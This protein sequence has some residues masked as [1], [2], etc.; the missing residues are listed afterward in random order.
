MSIGGLIYTVVLFLSC[1]HLGLKPCNA[2]TQQQSRAGTFPVTTIAAF[3]HYTHSNIGKQTICSPPK[4]AHHHRHRII[5]LSSSSNE[6]NEE[7]NDNTKKKKPKK[8]GYKFGDFTKSFVTKIGKTQKD[9]YEFGDLSKYLDQQA[10]ST[11]NQVTQKDDYEFGDL[12]RYIDSR[13][14]D[15]VKS[16][17]NVEEYAFG[18]V[19][20]EIVRRVATRDFEWKDMV[21]LMKVLLSFGV[22]FSPVASFLP[23]K[24]LIDLLNYSI[25]ADVGDRFVG[26]VTLEVDKRMK[27]AFTGDP[28]YQVGDLSKKA[29]LGYLDKEE[30]TFGD[31]TKKV[32]ESI[33]EN[34]KDVRDDTNTKD[35]M[36]SAKKS[37]TFLG[38]MDEGAIKEFE[39]WDNKILQAEELA[40]KKE[41]NLDK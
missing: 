8:K 15:E 34:K 32:L 39:A 29:I 17:A 21:T 3:G 28:D 1:S 14:K 22:G 41:G 13:V 27:K 19:T 12:S 36:R 5:A 6:N 7:T 38:E 24:F 40:M 37:L 18:D 25:T 33:E 2:Y 9:D 10:K 4:R 26:A 11:I 23:V 20:K 35:G 30:Y 31:V 16:F